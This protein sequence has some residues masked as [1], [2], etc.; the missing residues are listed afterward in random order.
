MRKTDPISAARISHG[1]DN[2]LGFSIDDTAERLMEESEKAR[3][4]GR[5]YALTTARNAAA[6]VGRRSSR[7][8]EP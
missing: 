6:A 2:R 5:N 4:Q 3:E 7:S 8:I 1:A